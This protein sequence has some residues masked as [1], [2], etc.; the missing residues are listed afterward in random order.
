[1]PVQQQSCLARPAPAAGDV[2]AGGEG[3]VFD[4]TAVETVRQKIPGTRPTSAETRRIVR[5]EKALEDWRTPWTVFYLRGF[6]RIETVK[7]PVQ[8]GRYLRMDDVRQGLDTGR[9]VVPTLD[10]AFPTRT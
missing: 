5:D 2:P 6:G 4:V 10:Q 9:V 1:M 8:Q 7:P 3:S